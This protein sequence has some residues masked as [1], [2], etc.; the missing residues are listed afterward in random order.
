M[1]QHSSLSSI[2]NKISSTTIDWEERFKALQDLDSHIQNA[3]PRLSAKLQRY[4][5]SIIV[6]NLAS[7]AFDLRSV[8]SKKALESI[9]MISK[10]L[11]VCSRRFAIQIIPKLLRLCRSS[12]RLITDAARNCLFTLV[13]YSKPVKC[14]EGLLQLK[15]HPMHS[16]ESLDLAANLIELHGVGKMDSASLKVLLHKATCARDPRVRKS[17]QKVRQVL[18][19]KKRGKNE[20]KKAPSH[21]P[22]LIVKHNTVKAQSKIAPQ[23]SFCTGPTFSQSNSRSPSNPSKGSS[24]YSSSMSRFSGHN[25]SEGSSTTPSS[26]GVASSPS[27]TSLDSGTLPELRSRGYDRKRRPIFRPI[28]YNKTSTP[29]QT[30][31]KVTISSSALAQEQAE[32]RRQRTISAAREHTRVLRARIAS[33]AAPRVTPLRIQRR[34]R[35]QRSMKTLNLSLWREPS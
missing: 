31:A 23:G 28:N 9:S 22:G 7:Q 27:A 19:T 32:T 25:C 1:Y 16:S 24:M 34:L 6:E 10:T 2:N 5:L 11:G 35:Q 26:C 12:K 3:F 4:Q 15:P 33:A 21:L 30:T 18:L 14:L 29:L 8:I 13:Q 20:G 17:A